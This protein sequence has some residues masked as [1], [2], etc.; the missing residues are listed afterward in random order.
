MHDLEE[1]LRLHSVRFH[2][3]EYLQERGAA[4]YSSGS[5]SFSYPQPLRGPNTHS[6]YFGMANSPER[7]YRRIPGAYRQLLLGMLAVAGEEGAV[8]ARLGRLS[9]SLQRPYSTLIL[10]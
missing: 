7:D 3:P 9:E 8:P 5:S 10:P 2:V 4:I 1:V 6:G